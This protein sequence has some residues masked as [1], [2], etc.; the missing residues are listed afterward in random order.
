MSSVQA[1]DISSSVRSDFDFSVDKFPLSGPD[2]MPTD[3]YGLF[4]S[5]TGYIS[6]V[7]SIS[8]RY[9][10]HTTDD[11]C[12]LVEAAA[13]AFDGEV[14]CT[15][16]WRQGHYVN[17]QPTDFDRV[18]VFGQNDNVWPRIII[19]AGYDGQAFTGTMGYY[20]DACLNL[21]MMQKVGGTTVSIRHTSGLR[22]A[23]DE[24]INTFNLLKDGWE[25]LTQVIH[26]LESKEVRMS[27]FLNEI[28]G[29]PTPEQRALAD[30]GQSVRAVTT[31]ENRTEAIWK[32]LNNE[33]NKT[34]RPPMENT[35]SAWEAYNAIQG[36]VQH[37]AQ[38]KTGFKGQF[39]R[40]LRDSKDANVRKAE[41]LVLEMAA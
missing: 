33:R 6:G 15:T 17:I 4:R 1:C 32:R 16:H 12:A 10:P 35:V 8:D 21:A 5:D 26:R 2:N 19:R 38:A 9:V 20:R 13:E 22:H 7:K 40:I 11:V 14:S 31:H 39:D 23:M 34:G 41:S 24:L 27:D 28:Y 37:D 3:Q 25:N 18:Q 36:Y 29:E 30:T